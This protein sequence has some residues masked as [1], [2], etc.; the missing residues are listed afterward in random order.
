MDVTGALFCQSGP[1]QIKISMFTITFDARIWFQMALWATL[2]NLYVTSRGLRR[3]VHQE[4]QW[5]DRDMCHQARFVEGLPST[6]DCGP[7]NIKT[8]QIQLYRCRSTTSWCHGFFVT[9]VHKLISLNYIQGINRSLNQVGLLWRHQKAVP[10]LGMLGSVDL[11]HP[12]F[13]SYKT[14]RSSL[15][16]GNPYTWRDGIYIETG[17]R[18]PGSVLKLSILMWYSTLHNNYDGRNEIRR[19]IHKGHLIVQWNNY[20]EYFTVI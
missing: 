20:C 12:A 19:R 4:S 1:K 14:R 6:Q 8:Y 7:I 16:N 17:P 2:P 9:V 10:C 11:R 15:Y 13:V 5:N 18:Q 3:F